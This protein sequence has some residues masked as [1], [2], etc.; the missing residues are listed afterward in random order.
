MKKIFYEKVGKRYKPVREY[1]REFMDSFYKGTTL[2]VCKPGSTSYMYDVDPMFAPMVAAGKYAEDSVSKT[3]VEALEYKPKSQPLTERQRELWEELKQS[4][5]D[6]DFKIYG[7]AAIDA[8]RAG[9]KA[10][11]IEAEKMLANPAVKKAYEHFM[12]LCKLT[13]EL[14][15]E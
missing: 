1:D 9:V 10:M 4:F 8:T 12:L 11:E 6:Q 7:P 13:K 5:D 14:E 3:I 2:V 15:K